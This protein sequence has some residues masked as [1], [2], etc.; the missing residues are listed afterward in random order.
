MPLFETPAK[1]NT[2]AMETIIIRISYPYIIFQRESERER[3]RK[4][5]GSESN[6]IQ[7]KS[8]LI[9]H[10]IKESRQRKEEE[11]DF[12]FSSRCQ[13]YCRQFFAIKENLADFLKRKK[14]FSLFFC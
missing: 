7:S 13:Y 4:S 2:Q 12:F 9:E 14:F 5:K 1:K 8:Y 3:K 10:P 6:L 11:E